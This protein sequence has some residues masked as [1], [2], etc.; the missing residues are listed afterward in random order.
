MGHHTI[1]TQNISVIVVAGGTGSRMGGDIPKQFMLIEDRPILMHTIERFHLLLPDANYIIVIH[2]DEIARWHN[3]CDI[4]SFN[5]KH[6]IA[7]GGKTRFHSVKNGLELVD[8]KCDVVMIHDGVRPF[9]DSAIIYNSL[10]KLSKYEAVVPVVPVV[11]SL[12]ELDIDGSSHIVDR[13][14]FVAVQTPQVFRASTLKQGYE[15]EYIPL[16]TD[17]ASVVENMGV[18][19]GLVEG[20]RSNIKITTHEDIMVASNFIKNSINQ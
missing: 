5:I 13:V 2:P 16:F 6:T 17:D 14:R 18:F 19:V 7:E 20:V 11:D 1:D 9:V 12:R 15:Q 8:E 3:L 10:D 4:F